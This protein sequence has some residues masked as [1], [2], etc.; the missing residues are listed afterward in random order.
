[1]FPKPLQVS[2][3][4]IVII[5][6]NVFFTHTHTKNVVL[7]KIVWISVFLQKKVLSRRKKSLKGIV[8]VIVN[9]TTISSTRL[10]SSMY[11]LYYSSMIWAFKIKSS[12]SL[13]YSGWTSSG[14]CWPSRR[15]WTT[16]VSTTSSSWAA[17]TP[18][19]PSAAPT[20]VFTVI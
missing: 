18:S 11:T 4:K 17:A 20:T 8:I 9:L 2:A 13:F 15:R 7:T 12:L 19:P 14:W 1:M 6:V 5:D 10:W 16:S 3:Q